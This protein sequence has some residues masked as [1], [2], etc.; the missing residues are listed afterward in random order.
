MLGCCTCLTKADVAG[1]AIDSP[2]LRISDRYSE[3]ESIYSQ[4]A[5][6]SSEPSNKAMPLVRLVKWSFL[7]ERAREVE[8]A[9]TDEERAAL[10]LPRRQDL[11]TAR[12]DAYFSEKEFRALPRGDMT[13]AG[14]ALALVSLSHCWEEADHPDPMGRTL[15]RFARAVRRAIVKPVSGN[16]GPPTVVH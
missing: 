7:D 3:P 8:A 4:I 15:V 5:D 6:A 14:G 10:A 16:R 9:S 12:P 1:T 11:E 2:P 13:Y